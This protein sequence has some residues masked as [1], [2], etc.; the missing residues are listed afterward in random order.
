MAI[1]LDDEEGDATPSTD[2]NAEF[3][4][5]FKVADG[6]VTI[7]DA[8]SGTYVVATDANLNALN[9]AI[10]DA[11]ALL[12]QTQTSTDGTDV[13]V[14]TQWATQEAL[15]AYKAAVEE[16]TAVLN[17][18]DATED[19]I[20]AALTALEQAKADLEALSA[21]GTY[22][23]PAEE[24]GGEAAATTATATAASATTA[25][26]SATAQTGD[27]AQDM[28]VAG[29]LAAMLSAFVAALALRFNKR[30]VKNAKHA[31]K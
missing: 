15:D 30:S 21:E 25:D 27:N 9:S 20:D 13:A 17:N 14:G 2:P 6:A 12:E 1:D 10:N 11:N 5:S 3:V 28:A 22:V 18:P 19:E 24:Q 7:A 29:G 23:A 4:G 8:Q 26:G 31:S 16:V